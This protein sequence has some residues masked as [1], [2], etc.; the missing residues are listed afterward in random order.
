M[1]KNANTFSPGD[2]NNNPMEEKLQRKT[3]YVPIDIHKLM[4][5]TN[6][7]IQTQD[8]TV[9]EFII[10]NPKKALVYVSGG[11]LFPGGIEATVIS[12]YWEDDYDHRKLCIIQ[13]GLCIELKVPNGNMKSGHH[14]VSTTSV[15][16]AKITAP[17][18]SWSLEVWEDDQ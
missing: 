8:D 15:V 4:V 18:Q 16:S 10:I 14:Y 11:K 9:Y 12:S 7:L 13:K 1:K 2:D 5:G 6:I 3:E 17:D